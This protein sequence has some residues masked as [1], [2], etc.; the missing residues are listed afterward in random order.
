[1]A[2][3][4]SIIRRSTRA[5]SGVDTS[6]INCSSADNALLCS[7]PSNLPADQSSAY[8]SGVEHVH[9]LRWVILLLGFVVHVLLL[10]NPP[11]WLRA[12][13]FLTSM[14]GFWIRDTADWYRRKRSNRADSVAVA[15][16]S[17]PE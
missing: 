7:A 14:V 16:Q 15:D 4:A 6:I 1:M 13:V 9:R 10:T 3:A 5:A 2:S 8:P 12:L 17:Q 11:D